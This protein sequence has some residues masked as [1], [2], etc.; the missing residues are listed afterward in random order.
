MISTD[1][2]AVVSYIS[3]QEGTHSPNLC[4]EV[5]KILK[6]CLKQHIIVRIRI[7]P[8]KYNVLAD[9]LSRMDKIIK[10]EW[11]LDQSI[12]NSIFQMF[13]YPSLDLF[14]TR[15]ITNLYFMHPQFWIIKPLRW[16]HS[17]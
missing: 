11:T 6:W 9:R 7:I 8:G 3:K 4:V 16:P 2:T 13:N 10:T 15:F 14:A 12:A 17:P 1:N 5:R